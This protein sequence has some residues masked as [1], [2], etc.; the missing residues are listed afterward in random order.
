MHLL[1]MAK[2]YSGSFMSCSGDVMAKVQT[3]CLNISPYGL[4]LLSTI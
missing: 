3:N 4:A 2:F 1:E